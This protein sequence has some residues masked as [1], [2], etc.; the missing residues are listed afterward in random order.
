LVTLDA[1]GAPL[2]P[3]LFAKAYKEAR[4]LAPARFLTLRVNPAVFEKLL[5]DT[6]DVKE[7]VQAGTFPGHLGR[8]VT[9]IAC[10]AAPNGLG[11]GV[12]VKQD[13][14]CLQ[15][16]IEFQIHGSTELIVEHLATNAD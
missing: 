8:S 2:T 1:N 5:D 3:A 6:E 9:K 10:V 11:D 7:I 13:K 16:Q 14:E 12:E 15:S 4:K